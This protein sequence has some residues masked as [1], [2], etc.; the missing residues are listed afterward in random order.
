MG[1]SGFIG[2]MRNHRKEQYKS[3]SYRLTPFFEGVTPK[4]VQDS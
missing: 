1:L 3:I 4:I 2:L